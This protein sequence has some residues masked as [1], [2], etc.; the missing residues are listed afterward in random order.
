L[1]GTS[2]HDRDP[3]R[4]FARSDGLGLDLWLVDVASGGVKQVMC[5]S[6]P[7]PAGL[8]ATGVSVNVLS[9]SPDERYLLL[10][11][12]SVAAGIDYEGTEHYVIDLQSGELTRLGPAVDLFSWRTWAAPHTLYLASG[13]VSGQPGTLPTRLR[14][15]SPET[16]IADL[17]P[18]DRAAVSPSY[19]SVG[20]RVLYVEDVPGT[21]RRIASFDARTGLTRVLAADT[22]YAIDGVRVSVDGTALLQLRRELRTGALEIWLSDAQGGVAHPL[23]RYGTGYTQTTDAPALSLRALNLDSIAWSR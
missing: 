12:P 15:W 11:T 2:Q 20:Q 19:D 7:C 8:T 23:I 1:T 4:S 5:S 3:S 10:R 17:T 18:A 9:W 22:K 21:P 16:G 14:Q 6:D 13:K